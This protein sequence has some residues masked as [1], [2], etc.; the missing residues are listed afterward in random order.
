MTLPRL[1]VVVASYNM[2]RELPR[3]ARSLSP[4][5][6]RGIAAEDYELIFVD[7]DSTARFDEAAIHAAT[8]NASVHWL[9]GHGVSPVEA[10]NFGLAK[11]RGELVG[12]FIDG[13]RMASPGLLSAAMLAARLHARPAIGTLGFHLG[14]DLQARSIQSGYDQAKEDE[15][16]AASGWGDDGYR[17]FDISVFAASSEQGWFVVPAEANAVFMTASHWRDLGGYDAAFKTPGGGL[18]NH[19]LWCR[20]CAD[21]AAQIIMLLGEGTFHQVHGGIATNAA[22]SRWPLF[23][24]E[25]VRIRGHDYAMPSPAAWYFGTMRP[26]LGR[27]TA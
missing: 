8:P 26:A 11:A 12:V 21:P 7:N 16:L 5:M 15:L 2:A 9:K 6:Q 22:E 14:P 18:A 19:D 27:G 23:H 24:G 10:I 20:V 17:L 4:A 13:A 25:Y 1:S 3:T